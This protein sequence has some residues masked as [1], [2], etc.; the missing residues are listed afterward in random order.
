MLA[1]PAALEE[2]LLELKHGLVAQHQR[3][4]LH[5]LRDRD[6]LELN[7]VALLDLGP[8]EHAVV[9]LG[10]LEQR[11][12]REPRVDVRRLDLDAAREHVAPGDRH[13]VEF[14]G[15]GLEALVLQQT[16][17]QRLPRVLALF[18]LALLFLLLSRIGRQQLAALQEREG[19]GHDEVVAGDLEVHGPHE[20][21]VLQVLL[22]NEGD[23]DVEDVELV[24]AHQV[25]QQIERPLEHLE[26]DEVGRVLVLSL[27]LDDLLTRWRCRRLFRIRG[28][29]A[30]ALEVRGGRHVGALRRL[31]G[32]DRLRQARS[33]TTARREVRTTSTNW[34][35]LQL[36]TGA[37]QATMPSSEAVSC[38]VPLITGQSIR[39][40]TSG[41]PSIPGKNTSPRI[42]KP[43]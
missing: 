24:P 21:E 3:E 33:F 28:A 25:Q 8:R 17:D 20:L 36:S 29:H 7:L 37:R 34:P 15:C 39:L 26:R 5:T 14:V 10:E 4:L 12:R 31:L 1:R 27:G 32:W 19:R 30:L 40:S 23:R 35:P 13:G 22:R 6:R 38:S 11:D 2:Q 42:M 16:P 9:G 18:L 43:P 41:S